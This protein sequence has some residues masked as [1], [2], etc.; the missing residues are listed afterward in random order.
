M[1]GLWQDVRYALRTLGRQP[2]STL[3]IVMTL[4]LGIGANT[5]IFSMVNGVLLRSLPYQRSDQLVTL[6]QHATDDADGSAGF[7]VPEVIDYREQSA[8]LGRRRRIPH[9]VVQPDRLRRAPAGADGG[10]LGRLLR[11]HGG[12]ARAGAHVPCGRRRARRRGGAGALLRLLA[13][14]VRRREERDR[15]HGRDERPRAH[16]RRRAAAGSAVSERERR[17]HADHGVSLS[18]QRVLDREP[19]QPAA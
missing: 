7:S 6:R 15:P 13:A 19:R 16:D 5:A 18:P 8:E 12:A 2:G 3:A 14:R 10:R 11:R 9:D 4:A 1:A 17:L